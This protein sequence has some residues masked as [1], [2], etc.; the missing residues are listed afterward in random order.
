M[1]RNTINF[2]KLIYI[3]WQLIRYA[4]L[5][6]M[7]SA[8]GLTNYSW[9]FKASRL[10]RNRKHDNMRWGQR[11]SSCLIKLGP[12]FIKF[13]QTLATR[14]DLIGEEVA[15]DLTLLQDRLTPFSFSVA[16]A[17]IE[18]ETGSSIEELF[19]SFDEEPIAAASIAQVHGAVTLDGHDVAV[20]VLRPDIEVSFANDLSLFTWIAVFLE[21]YFPWTTRLHPIK[22]VAVFSETVALEMDMRME[23][24]AASELAEN[25]KNDPDFKVPLVFWATTTRRILT[26]ERLNGCRPDDKAAIESA[27]LDPFLILQKSTR[28]FF[29]QVFR[30]GF[31]HADMHPGN[32]FITE[33]GKVAPVDFG[34]MGR[35]DLQTR[36]FLADMLTGFL[37]RDY[38]RVAEVHFQAGYV[39][40][41]QSLE[42]FAQACRS[43][44]EPILGLPLAEISLAKL[45]S[46]LFNITEKFRMETQPQLLLLQK[47]M[48]VAEGV[49]RQLDDKVN[50]WEM[51]RPL[52]EEW[53]IENRSPPAIFKQTA[54]EIL[55]LTERLP[56]L[57]NKI[58][59][60]I[61]QLG[62]GG[63]RLHPD[64]THQFMKLQ[65]QNKPKLLFPII[66]FI[67]VIV[68]SIGMFL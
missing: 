23:A 9:C 3:V 38:I 16:K 67:S 4:V 7:S 34:I 49:G 22:I 12:S 30:D 51:A 33:D 20:K 39:P 55:Y 31:F 60:I 65:T 18:N 11:I 47:T 58:E 44:G 43:I 61:D 40:P 53:M 28:I 10:L 62:N 19:S 8:K 50:I 1:I 2:I 37:T 64:T 45:L 68:I 17:I 13:G 41:D 14:S 59:S 63:L 57:A 27:G 66:I 24:A 35:L 56:T 46:H 29:N 42:V 25:F 48:L 52:I 26:L 6:P 21:H 54:K 32:V 15:N 5:S 36:F